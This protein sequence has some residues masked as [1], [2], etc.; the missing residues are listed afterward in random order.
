MA[1]FVTLDEVANI[2]STILVTVLSLAV[3]KSI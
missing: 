3:R 1:F 2:G